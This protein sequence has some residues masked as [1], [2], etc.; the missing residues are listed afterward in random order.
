MRF[1]G[2]IACLALVLVLGCAGSRVGGAGADVQEAIAGLVADLGAPARGEVLLVPLRDAEGEVTA[3]T[4][5]L[6]EALVSALLREGYRLRLADDEGDKW[7]GDELPATHWEE[8]AGGPLLYGRV[9]GEGGFAFVQVRLVGP[10]GDV[11]ALGRGRLAAGQL[12]RL[13]ADRVRSSGGTVVRPLDIELHL[14]ARHDED[15]FASRVELAEGAELELGD[16]L[17]V[18]FKVSRD[19]QVYA[20]L[21]DSE[22]ESQEVVPAGTFYSGRVH[23]G[24]G[25]EAWINP[26]QSDR[27]YTLYFIVAENLDEERD[28]MFEEMRRLLDEGRVDRFTGLELQDA[29][30]AAYIDQR[31]QGDLVAKVERGAEVTLAAP[32]KIIYNDGTV[33]ESRHELLRAR[34]ALVR[35]VSFSVY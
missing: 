9:Q 16:R 27:V 29:V 31:L 30:V 20:F 5:L 12:Q 3:E 35:A 19:A 17:Q 21:Y 13:A 14:V 4:R 7:K 23:Y 6:D 33:L 32:E 2:A 34:P 11:L 26:G 15:Q 10:Q 18:R 8:A 1:L 25:K 24:P 28:R 22:G